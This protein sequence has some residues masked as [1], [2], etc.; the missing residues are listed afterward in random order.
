MAKIHLVA[1]NCQIKELFKVVANCHLR[2]EVK[3]CKSLKCLFYLS[4]Y[5][6]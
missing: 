5:V 1:N 6:R 4:V 3:A 2:N